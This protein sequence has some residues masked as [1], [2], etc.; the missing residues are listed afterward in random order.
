MS[1][2]EGDLKMEK[3]VLNQGRGQPLEAGKWR[4]HFSLGPLGGM[5]PPY[6]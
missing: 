1:E 6:T 5:Q 3:G 2:A 4:R